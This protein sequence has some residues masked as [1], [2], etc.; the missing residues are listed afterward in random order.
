MHLK[1]ICRNIL[2]LLAAGLFLAG[3]WLVAGQAADLVQYLG[4]LSVRIETPVP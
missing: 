2:V 3:L 1:T 4:Q